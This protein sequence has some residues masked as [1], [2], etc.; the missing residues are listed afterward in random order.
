MRRS[1]L[2]RERRSPADAELP[3]GDVPG[4][5]SSAALRGHPPPSASPRPQPRS[6]LSGRAFATVRERPARP[7]RLTHDVW[8]PH[9][10]AAPRWHRGRRRPDGGVVASGRARRTG[11]DLPRLDRARPLAHQG[12]VHRWATAVVRGDDPRTASTRPP[13][14][15][16]A[17][18]RPTRW[19]GWPTAQPT[20][21]PPCGPA[22]DDLAVMTFLREAPPRPRLLGPT[23]VPRDDG[24]RPRRTA[25]RARPAPLTAADVWLDERSP[26]TASTSCSSA[27]GSVAPRGRAPNSPTRQ[28]CPYRRADVGASRSAGAPGDPAASR[29][30]TASRTE[31]RPLQRHRRR[32][33]PRPVEPRRHGRRPDRPAR[34][35]AGARRRSP[36]EVPARGT[37]RSAPTRPPTHPGPGRRA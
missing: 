18:P 13:S 7:G 17:A 25:A 9:R 19:A 2:R 31:A 36:G 8:L 16:R 30:A 1:W 22:P 24:A 28:R 21:S 3:V 14:R 23:A 20:S 12:M 6:P 15:P 5:E 11:A 33:L 26:S 10:R 37:P 29:R 4:E 34:R 35:V 32:P 27:S